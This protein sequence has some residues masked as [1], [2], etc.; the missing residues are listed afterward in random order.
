[1]TQ[2]KTTLLKRIS[3]FLA[4][5]VIL[6]FVGV[7]GWLLSRSLFLAGALV[8]LAVGLVIGFFVGAAAVAMYATLDPDEF[9]KVLKQ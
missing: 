1:M 9:L 4:L 6:G 7:F 5:A 8:G 3:F 2:I